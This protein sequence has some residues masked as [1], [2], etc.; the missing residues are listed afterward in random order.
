MTVQ[1]LKD[2]NALYHGSLFVRLWDSLAVTRGLF[3]R[4]VITVGRREECPTGVGLVR[5]IYPPYI[6]DEL[7]L[8]LARVSG[9]P[10]RVW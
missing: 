3:M 5:L 6:K 2:T 8:I 1:A 10:P 7:R 9:M 4:P